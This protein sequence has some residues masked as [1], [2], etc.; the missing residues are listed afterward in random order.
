MPAMVDRGSRGSGGGGDLLVVSLHPGVA[1]AMR[2]HGGVGAA[3]VSAQ[4]QF[5]LCMACG[6]YCCTYTRML[7]GRCVLFCCKAYLDFHLQH[8][9]SSS[10]CLHGIVVLFL[11]LYDYIIIIVNIII[12]III[13]YHY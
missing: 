8:F 13:F 1:L 4:V 7:H 10:S 3:S 9:L 2:R 12:I 6:G 11:L 5:F